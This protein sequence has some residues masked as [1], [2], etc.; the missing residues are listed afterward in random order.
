M[1]TLLK[2]LMPIK[3]LYEKWMAFGEFLGKI[4]AG[5]WLTLFYFLVITPVGLVWRILKYDPLRIR[6]DSKN[7]SYREG[8]EEF[9]PEYMENPY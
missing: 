1:R 6:W 7:L 4:I 9:K 5:F 3:L 8:G 2:F